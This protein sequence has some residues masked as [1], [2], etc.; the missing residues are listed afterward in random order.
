MG[1]ATNSTEMFCCVDIF[2]GPPGPR[3]PPGNDG[4]PGIPVSV[5]AASVC[6]GHIAILCRTCAGLRVCVTE[7]NIYK[8]PTPNVRLKRAYIY[9]KQ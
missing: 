1:I 7:R 9:T 6:C 2:Q 3:G 5:C 8:A 4:A